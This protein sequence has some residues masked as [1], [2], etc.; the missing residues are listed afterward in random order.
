MDYKQAHRILH[1]DTTR[2]ALNEIEY[3]GGF[4]GKEKKLAAVDEAC[5]VACEAIDYRI[6]KFVECKEWKGTRDTRFKCPSCKKF[7]HNGSSFCD[8]CGQAIKF[9]KLKKVDNRLEL[10]WS[11]DD[12]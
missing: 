12:G 3:Y 2:I 6:P 11:E 1:P 8:K 5:I 7:V 9:P 4:A 10:D